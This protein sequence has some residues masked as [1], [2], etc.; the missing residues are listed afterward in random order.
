MVAILELENLEVCLWDCATTNKYLNMCDALGLSGHLAV[1]MWIESLT[2]ADSEV[3]SGSSVDGEINGKQI[4]FVLDGTDEN[5][6]TNYID[7]LA[8]PT[9]FPRL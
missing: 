8:R 4:V 2:G 7:R 1:T 3:G 9:R 5:K 6:E